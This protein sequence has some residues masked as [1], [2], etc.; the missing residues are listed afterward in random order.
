MPP[1]HTPFHQPPR[2][3]LQASLRQLLWLETLIAGVEAGAPPAVAALLR[4]L[5]AAG[6]LTADL[7]LA[8]SA[9]GAERL[10]YFDARLPPPFQL[11]L[12]W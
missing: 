10:G 9:A 11:S 2:C 8:Q 4:Q 7:R 3:C 1:A 12:G 5:F 6:G